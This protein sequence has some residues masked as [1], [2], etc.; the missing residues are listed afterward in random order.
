[1]LRLIILAVLAAHASGCA[2]D[3]SPLRAVYGQV[4]PQQTPV[5]APDFVA[6]SR[7]P[8]GDFLPVGVSAPMRTVRP[9]SSEG[10]KALAVELEGARGANEAKGRAAQSAARS[11]ASPSKPNPAPQ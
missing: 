5:T 9:K 8:E 2:S 1:M 10:T 11:A 4:S 3:V 7:K 6:N